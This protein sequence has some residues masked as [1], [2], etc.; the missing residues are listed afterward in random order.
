MGVVYWTPVCT[1]IGLANLAVF[2]AQV[3]LPGAFPWD[4]LA[5]TVG[6]VRGHQFL[7]SM[8]LHTSWTHLTANAFFLFAFGAVLEKRAGALAVAIVYVV[9]GVGSCA[10][11]WF[12]HGNGEVLMGA[13]GAIFGIICAMVFLDPKA[14]VVTPGAP[15]PVPILVFAVLYVGQEMFQLGKGDLATDRIAHAAHLGGGLAGGLLGLL[16][17]DRT[18][19]AKGKGK[20]KEREE[21]VRRG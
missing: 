12:I 15:L 4:G 18:A 20:G 13:S 10:L 8:F 5:F 1:V 21:G 11:F 7:S 9:S 14:F 6:D 3:F 2:L 16:L 17:M 19:G